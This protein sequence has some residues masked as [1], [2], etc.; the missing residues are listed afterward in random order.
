MSNEKTAGIISL[1][2]SKNLV[3]SEHILGVLKE[4]G[5]EIVQDEEAEIV[6]VNTCGFIKDAIEESHEIIKE[7]IER[8]KNGLCK[9]LIVAGCL[10]LRDYKSLS[11]KFP[12]I[13]NIVGS[14]DIK[15]IARIIERNEKISVCGKVNGQDTTLPRVLTNTGPS[16]YLKIS[17]GCSN[18]CTYCTIPLIK[19][20]L[21][22]RTI[23]S[24]LS[25]ART[26]VEKGALEINLISQDTTAF[27]RDRSDGTSLLELLKN[28]ERIKELRWIRLLY[29][30]PANLSEELIKYISD[31]EKV[32]KY[33]DLPLQ[34][35]NDR[36]LKRMGRGVDR[37]YIEGLLNK[38]R[39]EIPSIT[40][41]TTFIVGFPGEG[42]EEFRELYNFVKEFEFERLGV[43]KYSREKGTQAAN[44]EGQ[45]SKKIK[46][47]R[48]D[49][50]MRLQSEISL[51]KN[52]ELI[53][54]Y[55]EML[56]EFYNQEKDVL[57]G[58]ISSQAPEVDGKTILY[59]TFPESNFLK[60]KIIDATNYD[61]IGEVWRG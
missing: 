26:L 27:G 19:G 1:G 44:F 49:A 36:I 6:I 60:V 35:I 61:L 14:Y 48:Y 31:S 18:N 9:K 21:K 23:E 51:K 25:E 2:C 32:C 39:R 30:H 57:Y 17:E 10:P 13:D 28:L 40:L 33:L 45:V 52:E 47:E 59:D 34:H 16:T 22:S 38:L 46:D 54:R 29:C 42:E 53:G 43:F 15:D 3:D 37:R 12:E 41:R 58:R 56:I 8:K 55:N 7:L 20:A 5:Y 50:I 4:A 24:I 11:R